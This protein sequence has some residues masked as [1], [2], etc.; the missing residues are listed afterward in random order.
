MSCF[1]FHK[2]IRLDGQLACTKCG[3][4][5]GDPLLTGHVAIVKTDQEAQKLKQSTV[6]IIQG[7]KLPTCEA[8]YR[9]WQWD[10]ELRAARFDN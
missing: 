8:I 4:K 9:R 6:L 3:K 5:V 7:V 1:I 2:W 10:Q